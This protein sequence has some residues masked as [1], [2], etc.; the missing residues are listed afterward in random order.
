MACSLL[1]ALRFPLP[2][3]ALRAAGLRGQLFVN[4]GNIGQLRPVA[5]LSE[6]AD[7]FKST[8]R[9]SVVSW[10]GSWREC[11]YALNAVSKIL[12]LSHKR[13]CYLALQG[14]GI[15]WPTGIGKL[16]LNVCRVMRA[17]PQDRVKHG[18]QFG[19]TPPM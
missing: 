9:C 6:A 3:E 15:V 13:R 4:A 19:I 18:I 7:A 12:L 8:L 16:E 2:G 14:A 5:S 11:S 1:A 17:G 10:V